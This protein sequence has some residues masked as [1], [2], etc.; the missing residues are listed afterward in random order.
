MNYAF[1]SLEKYE[2]LMEN[3]LVCQDFSSF[4]AVGKMRFVF[5][6]VLLFASGHIIPA[7]CSSNVQSIKI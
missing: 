5:N 1:K 6:E 7:F 3:F 2:Y 4:T